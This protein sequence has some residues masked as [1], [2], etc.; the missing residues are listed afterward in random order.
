MF[1]IFRL[2]VALD[3]KLNIS[4][5]FAVLEISICYKYRVVPTSYLDI[6]NSNQLIE[7]FLRP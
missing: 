1:L 7:T 5:D 6:L 3:S 4:T 2:G